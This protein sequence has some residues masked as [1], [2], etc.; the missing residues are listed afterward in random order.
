[1]A[2]S[3]V[4]SITAEVL[5]AAASNASITSVAVEVLATPGAGQRI[6]VERWGTAVPAAP[7]AKTQGLYN[8]LS[9]SAAPPS[10]R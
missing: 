6:A 2:E 3:R 4:T 8:Q 7:T 9:T 1:M 5:T 10:R